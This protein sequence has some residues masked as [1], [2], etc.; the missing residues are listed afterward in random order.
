[1][2]NVVTDD[3][4]LC[5]R[6]TGEPVRVSHVDRVLCSPRGTYLVLAH[7]QSTLLGGIFCAVD[8]CS[9]KTVVCAAFFFLEKLECICFVRY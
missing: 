7:L 3:T 1:M 2:D 5:L 9:G 6:D 8:H 4:V